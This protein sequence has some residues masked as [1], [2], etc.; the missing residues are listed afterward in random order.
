MS[1]LRVVPFAQKRQHS[2]DDGSRVALL[3]CRACRL[4]WYAIF[5]ANVH[6]VDELPCPDCEAAEAEHLNASKLIVFYEYDG[7]S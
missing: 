2:H 3:K 7:D 5:D 4:H 1:D 6:A